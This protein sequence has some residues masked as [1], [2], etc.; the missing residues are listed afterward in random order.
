MEK[1]H[2]KDEKNCFL[3]NATNGITLDL[4]EKFYSH[5]ENYFFEKLVITCNIVYIPPIP[6][7]KTVLGTVAVLVFPTVILGGNFSLT[8]KIRVLVTR[9]SQGPSR[10]ANL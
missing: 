9:I 6:N 4:I 3:S 1:I 5:F 2:D 10:Y 8:A 7:K